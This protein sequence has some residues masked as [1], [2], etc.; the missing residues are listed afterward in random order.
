MM[1]VVGVPHCWCL[2][3]VMVVVT[4]GCGSPSTT[5]D[6]GEAAEQA[7]VASEEP[8][9]AALPDVPGGVDTVEDYVRYLAEKGFAGSLLIDRDGEIATTAA[10]GE[11]DRARNRANTVDTV[12]DMGSI[13][14]TFTAVA[15]LRLVDEGALALDDT[16]GDL[17]TD[18]PAD[19]QDITV[20]QLLDFT[21]G[22]PEY[23]DTEGDFQPMTRGEALR[24]ILDEPLRFAPGTDEAYSNS[25]YTL[26]AIV[27]E[28][29]SGHAF[30]D[31]VE[32][33]LTE[34]GLDHTAFYGSPALQTLPVATGYEGETHG[35]NSPASW[36]PPSWALLGAGGMASSVGD[37]HTWWT[38][39]QEPGVLS[40]DSLA[41]LDE[42]LFPVGRVGALEGRAVGGLTDFGF[43]AEIVHLPTERVIIVV[44]SNAS[45]PERTVASDAAFVLARLLTE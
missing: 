27:I 36:D 16:L 42:E 12:F 31:E 4:A 2:A 45:P 28:E 10:F 29:V 5:G 30:I 34:V 43:N 15:I 32:E 39:L 23:H 37:L 6:P 38:A 41:V 9:D 18:V 1:S 13:A 22:L 17:L 8:A 24:R 20:R 25:S 14:K 26:A 11:A 35:E 44:V 33:L 19:K 3:V 21:S 7:N 40:T